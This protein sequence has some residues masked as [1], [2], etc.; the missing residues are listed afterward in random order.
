MVKTISNYSLH[1]SENSIQEVFQYYFPD[2]ILGYCSKCPNFGAFWSCPPHDFDMAEYLNR[3]KFVNVIGIK[4]SLDKN[5]GFDKSLEAYHAQKKRF[6]QSLLLIESDFPDCEILISGHCWHCKSC[7]R[8]KGNPCNFPDKKR[9]SL[10]SFGIKISEIIKDKFNDSLQWKK[11]EMPESLYIVQAI[12]SDQ[13][14][15][16]GKL[17]QRLVKAFG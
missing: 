6:N 13:R 12:L 15:D 11:G 10:E 3:Y 7:S 14:I 5:L 9:H 8:D 16:K 4:L 17:Q 1:I 2:E